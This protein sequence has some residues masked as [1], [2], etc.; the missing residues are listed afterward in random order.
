MDIFE[1]A[2]DFAVKAHS[3]AKRKGN[4]EPYILHP[5]E[6]AVIAG[7]LTK[8]P[9]IL[10]AAVLH[11]TVED[12]GA[13][14]EQIRAEFGERVASLVASETENKHPE[15]PP[16]E[17]WERRK[18]ET[19]A[20]LERTTDDAVKI[21]WISDKLSNL[22]SFR[23][24]KREKGSDFLECFNQKDIK[25][26]AWYYRKVVEYTESFSETD[27]RRELAGLVEEVFKGAVIK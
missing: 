17:S 24:L 5:M 18:T 27:A 22:R 3:G 1:K 6:V 19:L 2:I 10:A 9:E 16:Q 14:A 21:L 8:D 26:Q 11:D 13:T 20:V 15:L 4:G 7:T 25:K 12:T 23:R